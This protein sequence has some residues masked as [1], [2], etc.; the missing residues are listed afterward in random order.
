MSDYNGSPFSWFYP[1]FDDTNKRFS[2]GKV[3]GIDPQINTSN[4]TS[5]RSPWY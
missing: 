2:I 5:Y 1:T 4:Q 3:N